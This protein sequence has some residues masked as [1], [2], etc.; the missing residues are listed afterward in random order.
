MKKVLEEDQR[1]PRLEGE[2]TCEG[3]Q[4]IKRGKGQ[5]GFFVTKKDDTLLTSRERGS[6]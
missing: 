5:W 4:G 1:K 3:Q 2:K 6:P